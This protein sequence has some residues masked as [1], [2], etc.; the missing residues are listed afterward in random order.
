MFKS[1]QQVFLFFELDI[2]M[3]SVGEKSFP[4]STEDFFLKLCAPTNAK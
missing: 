1:L 4:D 3:L 2:L